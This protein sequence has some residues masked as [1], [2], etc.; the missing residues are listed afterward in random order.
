MT[1]EIR[2]LATGVY[3]ICLAKSCAKEHFNEEF[4]IRSHDTP[5][6][7]TFDV[8]KIFKVVIFVEILPALNYV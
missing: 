8:R 4:R 1:N 6:R 2:G 3:Q 7:S 5:T